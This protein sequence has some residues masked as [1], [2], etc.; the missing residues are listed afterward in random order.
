MPPP[1]DNEPAGASLLHMFGSCPLTNAMMKE[2]YATQT[3]TPTDFVRRHQA[4]IRFNRQPQTYLWGCRRQIALH[5]R[6]PG[7]VTQTCVFDKQHYK[8]MVAFK[9]FN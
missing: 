6:D 4:S 1:C 9:S 8:D 5:A 3:M 7:G 2:Y